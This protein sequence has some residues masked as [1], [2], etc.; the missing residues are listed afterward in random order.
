MTRQLIHGRHPV[1]GTEVPYSK[2]ASLFFN[3]ITQFI[4][5]GTMLAMSHFNVNIPAQMLI[6][7]L[8]YLICG[9]RW[10]LCYHNLLHQEKSLNPIVDLLLGVGFGHLL[11]FKPGKIG[12]DSHHHFNYGQDSRKYSMDIAQDYL[13]PSDILYRHKQ[14]MQRDADYW[15]KSSPNRWV[16]FMRSSLFDFN[17]ISFYLKK[18]RDMKWKYAPMTFARL[19]LLLAPFLLMN[20]IAY[21]IHLVMCRLVMT[22]IFM[23][24]TTLAHEEGWFDSLV[25]NFYPF[26]QTVDINLVLE[27]LIGYHIH[28]VNE[29]DNHHIFPKRDV[30]MLEQ[31]SIPRRMINFFANCFAKFVNYS[32]SKLMKRKSSSTNYSTIPQPVVIFKAI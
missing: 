6:L 8:V 13:T 22:V 28:H 2:Y 21:L 26:Q 5:L 15:C 17:Y 32:F 25:D 20:P 24:F 7:P 11:T 16:L 30:S 12:H 14:I 31:I 9:G 19:V 27:I 1:H 18:K 10:T 4:P 29:H 3:M 23:V